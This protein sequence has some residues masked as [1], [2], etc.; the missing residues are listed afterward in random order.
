MP[1]HLETEEVSNLSSFMNNLVSQTVRA[2][3]D[4]RAPFF[5]MI[6]VVVT[7][8]TLNL[9]SACDVFRYCAATSRNNVA[10]NTDFVA[11]RTV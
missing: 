5:H 2:L 8:N 7:S 3:K 10:G 11:S 1:D 4:T 9:S 6:H